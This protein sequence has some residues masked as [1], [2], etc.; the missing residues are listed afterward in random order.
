[1]RAG[2]GYPHDKISDLIK[3]KKGLK[4]SLSIPMGRHSKKAAVHKLRRQLSSELNHAG[5]L[6]LDFSIS[7]TV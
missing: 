1:M 2:E 7:R 5:T 3:K 6:I 4:S